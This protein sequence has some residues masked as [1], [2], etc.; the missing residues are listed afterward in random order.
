MASICV[1][2]NSCIINLDVFI[3]PFSTF[4]RDSMYR[5]G[6]TRGKIK[7]HPFQILL[8]THVQRSK[9]GSSPLYTT[10]LKSPQVWADAAVQIFFS[11]GT[12]WGSLATLGSFNK[13]RNNCLR[14]ALFVPV[15]NCATSFFAGFVVFSVLGFMAHKTGT[16][17]DSV[18]AAG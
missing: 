9:T 13:F 15:L 7:N 12:G 3:H 8:I 2:Y 11:I 16:S 4:D 1:S 14:D 6:L 5:F 10:S 18:T 17:V